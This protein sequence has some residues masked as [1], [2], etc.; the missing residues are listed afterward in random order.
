MPFIADLHLHSKYSRATSREM[1]V[2]SL[3]RWGRT[4]GIA[5]LGTG[6]FT[7]PTY[8]AELKAQLEPAEAGLFRLRRGE[9][10][11]RFLLS[12][13]VSNV[14]QEKGRLRK[15]HTVIF[16]PSFQAVERLN[17]ALARRGNLLA[18][19]RPT[20]GFSARD[21]ARLVLDISTDFF[22][23]PAHAWTPWF[24]LFGAHSGFDSLEECFGG[25]VKNIYAIE[26]GL[27]SDPAMNWR[28]SA[29]DG[30][31]LLSNSDA[32]SSAK[33]GREANVFDCPLDY[34]E[35]IK[36]I[37][38]RD[39]KR[40]LHTIEFFPEEGKYHYDGHR[41]CGVLFSPAETRRQGYLCPVCRKRLTVGV[42]HRVEELADRRDGFVPPNA[43][44]A[45]HLV[46]LEEIIAS[47]LGQGVGT[48][49]VTQ[50]YER[51]VGQGDSEFVIL[52]DLPKEE[53]ARFVPPRILEGILRVREGRLRI[54]PGYDG[55][56]GKIDI[57]GETEEKAEEKAQPSQMSLF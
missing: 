24:S 31:T 43:I 28:L 55:V 54:V 49:A 47:A 13:E 12:A 36:V 30:V 26:T 29:L 17:A 53:L 42:M 20:F 39:W 10:N 48:G 44:P 35:I 22:L 7:H 3:A 32:H 50:E 40:F 4:K 14:Y 56:Y 41:A 38:T 1:E 51:L 6:D 5:L 23:V 25:E 11:V 9:R 27:S 8:F 52:L 16:A 21:L 45:R 46:P 57:F 2:E 19:G 33:L 18:D 15:I 34:W 37:K